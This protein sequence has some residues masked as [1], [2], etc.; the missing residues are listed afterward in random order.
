M[1]EPRPHYALGDLLGVRKSADRKPSIA[2]DLDHARGTVHSYLRLPA[3][4]RKQ[5]DSPNAAVNPSVEGRRHPVLAGFED[6]DILAFG[7]RLEGL[8]A[9]DKA[10][11]FLTYV[12]PF[13]IY[14][15]ETAWMRTSHTE[16][17]GLIVRTTR[18]GSRIAFL[19]ADLDRRFGRDNLPDHGELLAS[20]VRWAAGDTIPLKV[21][22]KGVIDCH[23]YHQSGRMI[24]HLVNLTNAWMVCAPVH[25]LIPVGPLEVRVKLDADLAGRTARRLVDRAEV[26]IEPSRW[27]G[28][29]PDSRIARPRSCGHRL[30]CTDRTG[31]R[32]AGSLPDEVLQLAPRGRTHRA[33]MG[34]GDVRA[35]LGLVGD[36]DHCCRDW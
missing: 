27:L 19:A 25:E 15:P 21:E 18:R 33:R 34:R 4:P 9:I 29:F 1:G 12:P 20:L 32:A 2:E 10:E 17:P 8:I 3:G 28:Q 36:P 5:G 16:I 7:G 13:P 24:L 31:C 30:R 35:E 22:G 14:P 6:T 23:L 11:V 26:W